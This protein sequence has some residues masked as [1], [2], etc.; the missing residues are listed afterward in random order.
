M[1]LNHKIKSHFYVINIYLKDTS[2]KNLPHAW[3]T[4]EQPWGT[5]ENKITE[6]NECKWT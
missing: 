2:C 5:S 4:F 1:C 6:N 3:G